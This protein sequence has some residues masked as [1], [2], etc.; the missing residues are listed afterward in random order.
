MLIV[1][2]LIYNTF[3][4]FDAPSRDMC[5]WGMHCICVVYYGTCMTVELYTRIRRKSVHGRLKLLVI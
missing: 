5:G 4:L 1:A 3:T 2:G